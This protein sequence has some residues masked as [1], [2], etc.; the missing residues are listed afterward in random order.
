[1]FKLYNKESGEF[2]G[3]LS[4]DQLE[5][6]KAELEEEFLEDQDYTINGMTI[7]YLVSVQMDYATLVAR[8]RKALGDKEEVT[9]EWRDEES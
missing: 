2:L 8:L 3:E 5:F 6:L 7:E 9:I 1:M 4:S